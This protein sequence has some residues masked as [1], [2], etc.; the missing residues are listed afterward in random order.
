MKKMKDLAYHYGLKM[1]IYPSSQQKE[2][3]KINSDV[4]RAVYNKLIA[5]DKELY[6]LRQVKLPIEEIID[7]INELE[8]RKSAKNM[9]NHYPYMQDKRVDS[10]TLANAIKNYKNAWNMFRKVHQ[11]CV[12]KFRKKNER[13]NYQTSTHYSKMTNMD[14]FC[15][16]IRFLD[17][18][19][20]NLPKL[21]RIRVSGSHK[22]ILN[23]KKDV[24][25]GTV[26]INKDAC[27]RYFVSMLAT[28]IS[29]RCN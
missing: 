10:N 3:I 27:D 5:I 4:S 28:G 19:H 2:I 29:Y 18:N 13:E 17:D 24:R 25:I 7:R 8:K 9:A 16:S 1:R 14:M 15:A 12:P 22:R 23:N 6:Q 26:T 11:T 21:G 20:M